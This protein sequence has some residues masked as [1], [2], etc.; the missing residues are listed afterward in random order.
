MR[1]TEPMINDL[2]NQEQELVSGGFCNVSGG[3]KA[4]EFCNKAANRV[5]SLGLLGPTGL[6]LD[7][8]DIKE[9]HPTVYGAAR[10]LVKFE[11]F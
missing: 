9:Y 4:E 1:S 8:E 11:C 2:S 3:T 10:K 5:S 6:I 7:I